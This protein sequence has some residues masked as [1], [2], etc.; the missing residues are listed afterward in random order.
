MIRPVG[1]DRSPIIAMALQV[2]PRHMIMRKL[3]ALRRLQ[4]SLGV[5]EGA[6]WRIIRSL[7]SRGLIRGTVRVHPPAL[8]HP[9]ELRMGTSDCSVF[10]GILVENI[11]GCVDSLSDVKTVIDLGA[12][13]GVSS[14]FFLSRWPAARVIA[15]E[16]DPGSYALLRSNLS[17]YNAQ[18]I[19]GAVWG[20]HTSL[21]LSRAFGDGREWATAV[22]EG[23]GE[24]RAYTMD[25]LVSAVGIVD[26][27][28]INIEGGEESIFSGDTSW[29]ARVRNICIELHGENCERA[30]RQGMRGYRWEESYAHGFVMC[31]SITPRSEAAAPP[32]AVISE[33][34][35]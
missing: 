13:I 15:V 4:K 35:C 17:P 26:F 1:L 34:A 2:V 5:Y 25:E 30:F 7:D 3:R 33:R 24:V 23:A 9:V 21:T 28:K 31:R 27:L 11:F 32:R 29:V 22:L 20:R 16:P 19:Q 10:A 18:C 12:N 14:A 8:T 6:K